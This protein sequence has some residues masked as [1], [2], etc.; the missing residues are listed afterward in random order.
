MPESNPSADARALKSGRNQGATRAPLPR[1]GLALFLCTGIVGAQ[2]GAIGYIFNV[3]LDIDRAWGIGIGCGIVIAYTTFGGMRAVVVTD[4]LQFAIL[5][6]GMPL[7]LVFGISYVGG[8]DEV[9]RTVPVQHLEIPGSHYTWLSFCALVL[10]FFFGETLVPPYVQRLCIGR[11]ARAAARGVLYAGA[12]SI[13]FFAVTGLIGLVALT[14]DPHLDSNLA[15]PHV[16]ETAL[17]PFL[18]GLVI[19]AVVSIVM[20][21]ADSFLNSA[22]IAFVNDLVRPLSPRE[23]SD[24]VCLLLAKASTLLVGVVSVVFAVAIDSILDI[25]IYAYTYWAP[26]VIVPLVATVLGVR[27]GQRAFLAAVIGGAGAAFVWNQL[28]GKPGQIEGLV[29]GVFAN[30]LCFAVASV[31]APSATR[32]AE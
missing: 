9:V 14:M 28:L 1:Y 17:P 4:L 6:I 24:S 25:L 15:L 19:A 10:V 30:L 23:P 13:P 8:I 31:S 3:F 16:V 22:S 11:D 20:S 18:K 2:V 32:H 29:V 21:S 5:A 7:T 27:A 26:V 12:F